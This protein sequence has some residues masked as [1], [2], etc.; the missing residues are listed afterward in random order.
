MNIFLKRFQTDALMVP[1]LVDTLDE[2]IRS[3]CSKFILND[4]LE[5][6]KTTTSLIKLNMLDR[7]IQKVTTEVSFGLKSHLKDLKKEKKVKESEVHLFLQEVKQFLATL[8]NYLL[9]ISPINSHFARCCR[10]LNPVYMAQYAETCKKLFDK[11]LEKLV[12]CKHVTSTHAAKNEYS[13]A[14]SCKKKSSS[15]SGLSNQ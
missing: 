2:L 14:N 6:A 10:S 3:I 13:F 7:N 11:I 9:T 5:K 12:I 1:F 8:C 15:F 4:V